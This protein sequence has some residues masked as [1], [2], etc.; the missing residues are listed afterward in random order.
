MNIKICF[1]IHLLLIT[2][3]CSNSPMVN[4]DAYTIENG[5]IIATTLNGKNGNYN[6]HDR[7]DYYQ[8]PGIGIAVL[9]NDTVQFV[10][11]YGFANRE[12]K[13]LVDKNTI[14]QA[15]SVG[16]PITAL[17]ILKMAEANLISLDDDVNKYLKGWQIDYSDYVDSTYAS[18]SQILSHRSGLS[19]GSVAYY[20]IGEVIPT[21]EIEMLNATPPAK[22]EPVRLKFEPGT[23]W[24]YSG[25]GYTV[26]QKV[27]EDVLKMSYERA[28]DS[29]V[30]Q[31][32]QMSRSFF[33][34]TFT[35]KNEN[36]AI[37]YNYDSSP[38]N[39]GWMILTE[40]AA[41]G[42][43]T[44]P[45]DILKFITAIN[46]SLNGQANSILKKESVEKMLNLGLFVDSEASPT[47]FSFRGT[48]RGYRCEFVGFLENGQSH[49][50]MVMANS[51]NSRYLIQEILRN[52]SSLYEWRYPFAQKPVDFTTVDFSD[53]IANKISGK[54][55]SDDSRYNISI[56]NRNNSLIANRIWNN[57]SVNII[58]ISDSVFI[59]P[60]NSEEFKFSIDKEGKYRGFII[61]NKFP[62][63]KIE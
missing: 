40:L 14:F 9:N 41:G 60:S 12:K 11:G 38:V 58:Q 36:V 31:P 23:D 8:V 5:L 45:E 3:S 15:A 46:H 27:I 16:K 51:Y 6:I 25:G 22:L 62:Y 28:I 2:S 42:L 4:K 20:E 39:G 34:P 26:L 61:G 32:L 19:R 17:A 7:M 1:L 53:E 29:I 43:W 24:S 18:I 59:D 52:I 57:R 48:N 63:K 13:S 50:A 49:G 30:F 35:N 37:G 56:E 21:D 33:D 55:L 10:K 47:I 44:T 54:Y